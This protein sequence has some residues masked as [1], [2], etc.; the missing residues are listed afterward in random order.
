M[1]E[2]LKQL[3]A[4]VAT[5]IEMVGILVVT[6]GSLKGVVTVGRLVFAGGRYGGREARR[7]YARWLN[8][9]D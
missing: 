4:H 9:R 2:L 5:S 7:K 6:V 8:S 1:E 3:A